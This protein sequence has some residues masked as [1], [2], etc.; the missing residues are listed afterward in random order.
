M[1]PYNPQAPCPKCGYPAVSTRYHA[2]PELL[3][4]CKKSGGVESEHLHRTCE[5]CGYEWL[6]ACLPPTTTAPA[7][8][9]PPAGQGQQ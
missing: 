3:Q 9:Q 6:E 5:R 8:Y 1:N 7:P 2:K 4:I